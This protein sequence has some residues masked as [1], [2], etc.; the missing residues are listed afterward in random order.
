MRKRITSS[1]LGL[2][3]LV[4]VDLEAA[5]R[6]SVY[7]ALPRRDGFIDIDTAINDSAIDVTRSVRS[8]VKREAV[9]TEDRERADIVLTV[10]SRG[11]G[12]TSYGAWAQAYTIGSTSFALAVPLTQRDYWVQTVIDV[13]DHQKAMLG[14]SRSSFKDCAGQIARDLRVWILANAERLKARRRNF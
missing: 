8:V 13:G 5:E 11:Y 14:R 2:L 9:L 7:I 12:E 3:L 4:L 6:F 10:L 1:A